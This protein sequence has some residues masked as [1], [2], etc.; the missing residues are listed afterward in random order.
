[1]TRY[2]LSGGSPE[3]DPK[4]WQALREA[5][6]E[7]LPLRA[8]HFDWGGRPGR[9]VGGYLASAHQLLNLERMLSWRLN[10]LALVEAAHPHDLAAQA[11]AADLLWLDGG[12]TA[13]YMT[14]LC[15][16]NWGL[17]DHK[18]VVG[19]SA[20]ANALAR[21]CYGLDAREVLATFGPVP[22]KL[23]VHWGSDYGTGD[24]RGS[25]DWAVAKKL[26]QHTGPE[27][28]VVT[29]GEGQWRAFDV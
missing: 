18:V 22:V 6:P 15:R 16:M 27:L 13:E 11:K 7:A 23:V 21:S 8:V 2:F 5:L 4:F 20:G 29:L 26:L 10:C 17:L 24:P 14:K 12:T 25:V 19:C 3:G 9:G 1:M 28:P